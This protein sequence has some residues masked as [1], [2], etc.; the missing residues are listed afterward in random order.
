ML[1]ASDV[2]AVLVTRGDVDIAPVLES[3]IFNDVLVWDNSQSGDVRA[4]GRVAATVF[5]KNSV[6]YTQD[7]DCIV[8]S[9]AQQALLL[10]YKDGELISN[11]P[12]SHN[13]G[14]PLL[15]LMGWGALI[16]QDLIYAALRKWCAA[17]YNVFDEEFQ[18]VGSDIV[19]PVLTPSRRYDFGH[20]DLEYAHAP[21]RTHNQAFYKESKQ[22]YYDQ[23][24]LLR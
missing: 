7:D 8:S 2:T 23:A 18:R 22:W 12:A 24:S 21:D 4:F 11:M 3:L 17:G 19:I 16:K 13:A 10:A 20:V 9:E 6:I 5:A 1:V 14:H 15:A